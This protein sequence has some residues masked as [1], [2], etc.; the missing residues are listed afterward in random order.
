MTGEPTRTGT[1]QVGC[2]CRKGNSTGSAEA[3]ARN[4]TSPKNTIANVFMKFF[5][6]LQ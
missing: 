5:V 2:P 3:L 1:L 4:D 6:V